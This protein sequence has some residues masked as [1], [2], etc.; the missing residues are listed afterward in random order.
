MTPLLSIDILRKRFG[1]CRLLD[2]ESLCI[3]TASAYT[4][5]EANGVGKSILLR[6]L[7]GLE[8]DDAAAMHWCGAP[9]TLSPYPR[10]LRM[11]IVYVHQHPVLFS[12][13]VADNIAYGLRMRKVAPRILAERVDEA[14]A[15]AGVTHLRTRDTAH[16]S[17]G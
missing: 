14:L 10:V 1:Q 3:D 9:Q 11:A 17:G 13:S 8:T 16:L 7:A 12:G 15:L 4:L 2:I 6:I 5:T